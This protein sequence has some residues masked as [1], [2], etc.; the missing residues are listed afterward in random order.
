MVSWGRYLR[1][2]VAHF[3]RKGGAF[4]RPLPKIRESASRTFTKNRRKGVIGR[5]G[6][7]EGCSEGSDRLTCPAQP[8]HG[9]KRRDSPE[10]RVSSVI[11][12]LMQVI[13]HEPRNLI[14]TQDS[15]ITLGTLDW[16]GACL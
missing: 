4:S 9:G 10:G 5:R 15:Y 13:D 7:A 1:P 14:E 2:G 16:L 11:T 6:R 8:V 3:L 12:K